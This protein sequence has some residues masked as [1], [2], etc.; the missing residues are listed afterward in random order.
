MYSLNDIIDKE[1][2]AK[3]PFQ[4]HRPIASNKVSEKVAGLNGVFY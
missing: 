4:K 3:H 1:N 2:D